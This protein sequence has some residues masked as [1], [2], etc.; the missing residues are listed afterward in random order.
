VACGKRPGQAAGIHI[1]RICSNETVRNG[2]LEPASVHWLAGGAAAWPLAARAPAET[3]AAREEEKSW[4]PV[5]LAW[6]GGEWDSNS[7]HISLCYLNL[8]SG[9]GRSPSYYPCAAY[10]RAAVRLLTEIPIP[11]SY[12]T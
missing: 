12:W 7:A 4:I 8:S 1:L 11:W 2:A 3:R 9:V 10:P 6:D 5:P